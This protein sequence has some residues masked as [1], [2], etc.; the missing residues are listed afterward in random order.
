[1]SSPPRFFRV[2]QL[3]EKYVVD[4]PILDVGCGDGRIVARFTAAGHDC[5][6]LDID[7]AVLDQARRRYGN[8]GWV[9]GNGEAL[10]F[11]ENYFGSVVGLYFAAN[12]MNRDV[13]LQESARVLRPGGRLAYTLV[14]PTVRILEAIQGRIKIGR[15]PDIL[16]LLAHGKALGSPK[17]EWKRLHRCGLAPEP[18]VGPM[19][20]PW[21]RRNP[22]WLKQAPIFGGRA[23][24]AVSDVLIRATKPMSLD[25][26]VLS[27]TEYQFID[28]LRQAP[29]KPLAGWYGLGHA[30]I[31]EGRYVI[32]TRNG[33][34]RAAWLSRV[35]LWPQDAHWFLSESGRPLVVWRDAIVAYANSSGVIPGQPMV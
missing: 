33:L 35:S 3:V 22:S 11:P 27:G 14:N 34:T 16:R 7:K 32:A 31:E 6:G 23:I 21:L 10:P 12:L 8:L 4:G 18:L 9:Q 24:G 1:M 30:P 19:W 29:S 25:D 17:Q 15:N 28:R 20:M 2:D 26:A 13:F 5:I